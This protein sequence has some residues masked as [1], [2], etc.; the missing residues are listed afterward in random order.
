MKQEEKTIPQCNHTSVGIIVIRDEQLLLIER[1]K[2][3]WGYACPAGHV[4]D[5]EEFVAAARRE[6]REETGLIATSLHVF[7]AGEVENPCRRPGGAWHY[8]RLYEAV[9]FS[10]ELIHNKDEVKKIGWYPL[11]SVRELAE[12]TE[13]YRAGRIPEE[14][15]QQRPGI[16]PVWYDFLKM[17]R[18]I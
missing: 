6:L 16:E 11:A 15:W 7:F 4:E 10:G 14:E 13:E 5:G 3:P 18:I 12:R 1:Q 9:E 17:A 8:W 2:F